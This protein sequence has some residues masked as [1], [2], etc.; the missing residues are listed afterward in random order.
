MRILLNPFKSH[1]CVLSFIAFLLL[2]TPVLTANEPATKQQSNPKSEVQNPQLDKASFALKT[3]KLHMPFI[4]NNGQMDGQV[5]FYARTFGGTVFVTKEG[6]IVYALPGSRPEDVSSQLKVGSLDCR[7]EWHSPKG[8]HDDAGMLHDHHISDI[9]HP[10]SWIVEHD[11]SETCG[12]QSRTIQNIRAIALKEDVSPRPLRERDRVRGISLKEELVGAKVKAIQGEQPSVT[13]VS[14]FKGNDPSKWKTN[15]STY[16]SVNLG[17]IYD[18]IELKLRAYGNNVEKLFCINPGADPE[19]IKIGL[20]GIRSLKV[21]K[22]GL[23]EA[24]TG[25]GTVKFTE[26]VAYQEIDGKRVDVAARYTLITSRPKTLNSKLETLNYKLS[27]AN[28]QLTTDNCSLTYGFKVASYDKSKPLIID[29]LLASTFLG[30]SDYDLV[31]SLTLDTNGNVYVTGY[32]NSS[33]FPTTS[34]AYDTSFNNSS[35]YYDVFVSKLDGGL[36]SLLA[37]TYLGGSSSDGG[38]SLALDASGNVYVTGWTY[39]SDFPTT[40]GAYDTSFNGDDAFISK[41]NSDLSSLLASTYL[42]GSGNDNGTS[43][44]LDTSGNVYVTGYTQS[45]DFPTTSGA[46]DTYSNGDYDVFVSKLDS[47]LSNLLASTYLGGSNSDFGNSITLDTSGNVYV[48]GT[49]YST[50]FPTTSGAYD[51]SSVSYYQGNYYSDVFVSKLDSGLT[52][53]LASTYLGGSQTDNGNSLTLDTSGNVYVTGQTGSTNFPTT[54]GAYDNSLNSYDVFVSKLD[55]GLSNLLASTY[56][57]G[58]DSDY[59]NSI[60]LDT[61]GDVYVTGYTRYLDF[62]TTS[63]AYDTSYGGGGDVFV[64]KLNSGLSS[65]LASTYLGGSGSDQGSSLALDTNGD[66]YVT[67]QTGS[68][69]FPMTSGAYDTSYGGGG[70][71]FVSKLD[72]DLSANDA[73]TPTGSISINSGAEYTNTTSVTLNLSATD[74]WGVTGYYVSTNPFKPSASDAGWIDITPTTSYSGDV[75]YTLGS[76]DGSKSV[77]A[78]FK[79]IYDNVSSGTSDSIILDTTEPIVAITSPT[80][81]DT[82]TTTSSTISLSG[83]AMDSTSGLS[84]ITWSNDK[85]GSGTANG[86][87]NWNISNIS[88]SVGNNTITV[89]AT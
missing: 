12:E 32:T 26:P 80:S 5:K 81:D 18:G 28:G 44:A 78:W 83:I 6:E 89:T 59:G 61:S 52:S 53:L 76:G 75:P 73:T 4:A 21:N 3:A 14:Y 88:L 48:T 70:D 9:L 41:L 87:T 15:I 37:S 16:D 55:S 7:G 20:N 35:S 42:G 38:P 25:L 43:L 69:D 77:Y 2:F 13:K 57:G 79:D 8:I 82:Y 68:T 72:G 11:K 17:E 30:G 31:K 40:S 51:T 23:L 84:S 24:E 49:S 22:G 86:T 54:S 66:V 33:E 27:T 46:Y 47:G 67:G 19:K 50:D 29:P 74:E 71:V 85:G 39:S 1:L 60:T 36:T 64:S 56:L 10:A 45:T 34:G 58:S 62:P 63:G 65:L